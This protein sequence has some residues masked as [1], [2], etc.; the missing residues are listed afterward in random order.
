MNILITGASGFLGNAITHHLLNS[1]HK[2]SLLLRA[3]SNIHR[4]HSRQSEFELGRCNSE[5]EIDEFILSIRPDIVIHTA[6]TYGRLG[7]T[8]LQVSDS[9]L[10]YGL[11]IIDSL[12]R[13][14]KSVTFIN[15]GTTLESTVSTYALTKQQFSQSGR[16][17]ALQSSGQL[18]FINILLQHMYGPGDDPSKFTSHVLSS[19]YQ[20]KPTLN[21]TAGEQRRDLIFIDDVVSAYTAVLE[22]RDKFK[23]ADE[24]EV[25]SG[26]APTVREFV[27]TVHRMTKSNT[28]LNFGALPYR[29][30]EPMHCQANIDKLKA[31]GWQPKYDLE[32]GLLKT[33]ELEFLK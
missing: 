13:T 24:I 21:L 32:M 8:A 9:N 25:G 23:I 4:L 12:F 22:Q 28:Q 27:Q 15:T 17:L 2:V 20:N 30:N 6:C 7:E 19:C 14:K 26:I 11:V 31:L 16:L 3:T 29:P 10:R 33:L 18:R 1:V 5:K